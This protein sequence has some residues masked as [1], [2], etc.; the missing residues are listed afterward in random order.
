M[1]VGIPGFS[2]DDGLNGEQAPVGMNKMKL[3]LYLITRGNLDPAI[4]NHI[5]N[6]DIGAG[7]SAGLLTHFTKT[8]QNLRI[9]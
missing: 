6:K 1:P 3:P 2:K 8:K 9:Y 4:S 5:Y 7:A